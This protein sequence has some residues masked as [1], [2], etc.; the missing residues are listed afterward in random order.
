VS[1]DHTK[2]GD[3]KMKKKFLA[4]VLVALIAAFSL[5][6]GAFAQGPRGGG[7]RLGTGA[8]L[9]P[10]TST[11][12]LDGQTT[13]ALIDA[14]NDEYHAHAFYQAVIAKFGAVA[15]FTNIVRAEESHINIVKTLMTRY[16]VPIPADKFTGNVTMP[17]TL[18][19]AIQAAVDAEK[20]NVALYDRFT[21]VKETDIKAAFEQ[22]RAVSQT[23]HLPAFEQAL[24]GNY[25]P[26]QNGGWQLPNPQQFFGRR[27]AW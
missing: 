17:A 2:Q 3:E 1:T 4:G 23:R 12:T 27:W 9:P 8:N 16:N 14:L 15:P 11:A 26:I 10:V 21:F 22:M 25:A 18:N 7:A 20:A 24:S 13:Q 19:E 6:T 5:T